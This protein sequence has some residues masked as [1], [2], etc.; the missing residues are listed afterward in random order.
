MKAGR[1]ASLAFDTSGDGDHVIAAFFSR[2]DRSSPIR[3]LVSDTR[4]ENDR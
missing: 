1:R 2:S 3:N 4:R